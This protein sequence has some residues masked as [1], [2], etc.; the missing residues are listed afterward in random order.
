M[1]KNIEK[2]ASKTRQ[3]DHFNNETI[4]FW[5]TK[6]LNL[7]WSNKFSLLCLICFIEKY[8][9][10]KWAWSSLLKGEWKTMQK[11]TLSIFKIE[12]EK[13]KAS[14]FQTN[15]SLTIL[16]MK[17]QAT[18]ISEQRLKLIVTKLTLENK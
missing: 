3:T 8:D 11:I 4:I 14:L 5:L 1:N 10:K 13:N 2:A 18:Y 17:N 7:K 16:R 9:L 6:Q 15:L 12:K